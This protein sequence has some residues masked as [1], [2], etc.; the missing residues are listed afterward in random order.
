MKTKI[1]NLIS[2]LMSIGKT[3][4]ESQTLM[5][6]YWEFADYENHDEI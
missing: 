6:A 1:A 4:T 2:D 3:L 5:I